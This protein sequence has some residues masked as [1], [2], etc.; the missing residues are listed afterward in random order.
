[1]ERK[2]EDIRYLIRVTF[3]DRTMYYRSGSYTLEMNPSN[4]S[5]YY[6]KE[7]ANKDINHAISQGGIGD[8]VE[9]KEA[10]KHYTS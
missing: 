8:I 1:M 2:S 3:Q 7:S 5:R 4:A 6:S 10:Q 9:L